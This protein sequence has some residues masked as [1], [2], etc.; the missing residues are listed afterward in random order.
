MR[1]ISII[2]FLSVGVIL[3]GCV[4]STTTREPSGSAQQMDLDTLV[5]MRGRNLDTEMAQNGFDN[6]GGYKTGE[7]SMTTW[8][9]AASRQCV[10][11]ETREGR[12]AKAETIVEGNCQMGQSGGA[13]SAAQSQSDNT[14][15]WSCKT[16]VA[17]ELGITDPASIQVIGSEF[18]QA[19]TSVRV[20]APGAQ[21]PWACVIDTDG[22]VS[23]VYYSAEG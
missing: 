11:V 21:A 8:W 1:K 22:S 4:D 9:N 20:S 10:S 12:V 16:A 23:R 7:A 3:G 17:K 13:S 15:E 19:G 2:C 18:S 5:G 6:V 14:A